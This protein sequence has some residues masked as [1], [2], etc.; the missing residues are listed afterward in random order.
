MRVFASA[1]GGAVLA[2]ED[3][4]PGIP[5]ARRGALRGRFVRGEAEGEHPAGMGLGLA[6]VEEIAT[7]F[8][9]TLTLEDAKAG[10]QRGLV[11]QVA[12][13]PAA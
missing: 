6:I 9:G 2:V 5:P 4:G 8:G 7:L 3:D 11:V 1:E 12:F 10:A 13:P